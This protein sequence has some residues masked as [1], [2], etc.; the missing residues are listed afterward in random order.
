MRFLKLIQMFLVEL[1]AF[2]VPNTISK[3]ILASHPSKLPVNNPSASYK[4]SFKK[5]IIDKC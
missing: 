5:E 1:D 4:E 3:S 2:L